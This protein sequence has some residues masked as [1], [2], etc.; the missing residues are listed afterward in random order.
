MYQHTNE[1]VKAATT[2]IQDQRDRQRFLAR[3]QEGVTGLVGELIRY[4]GTIST[5]L[6]N[7]FSMSQSPWQ[8]IY[9]KTEKKQMT[10]RNKF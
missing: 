9:Y 2:T 7:I 10:S 5:K 8:L 4:P 3:Q 6:G 1:S